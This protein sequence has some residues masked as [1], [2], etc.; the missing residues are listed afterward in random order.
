VK[1]FS[2]VLIVLMVMNL[3]VLTGCKNE[4]ENEESDFGISNEIDRDEIIASIKDAMMKAFEEVPDPYLIGWTFSLKVSGL[5]DDQMAELYLESLFESLVVDKEFEYDVGKPLRSVVTDTGY[6]LVIGETND[7]SN[8]FASQSAVTAE[9]TSYSVSHK[10]PEDVVYSNDQVVVQI[11]SI[12]TSSYDVPFIEFV[13]IEGWETVFGT[14]NFERLGPGSQ[15][16]QKDVNVD[17]EIVDGTVETSIPQGDYRLTFKRDDFVFDIIL[18]DDYVLLTEGNKMIT[19]EGKKIV[20]GKVY[21]GSSSDEDKEPIEDAEVKLVPLMTDAGIED[22]FAG[23]TDSNGEYNIPD[24]PIGAYLAFVNGIEQH[25]ITIDQAGNGEWNVD[26][27]F[28]A[29]DS[30]DITLVIKLPLTTTQVEY[31]DV[32]I[33]DAYIQP[34][35]A[36]SGVYNITKDS[37]VAPSNYISIENITG[38]NPFYRDNFFSILKTDDTASGYLKPNTYYLNYYFEQ[39]WL[40]D[41]GVAVLDE[42]TNQGLV[43]S[44][45]DFYSGEVDTEAFEE[46]LNEGT[47]FVMTHTVSR[48]SETTITIVPH[49]E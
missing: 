46:L 45:D 6:Y 32:Y 21:Q 9:N 1:L 23:T 33:G 31:T 7:I 22:E 26:D 38:R 48:Y 42:V 30:Y 3:M 36:S 29:E 49:E 10:G 44:A 12:I 19:L 18:D 4:G 39:Y 14:L 15:S 37:H 8:P 27:M 25:I 43:V 11:S 40:D 24:V 16:E 35:Q 20:K 17:A 47:P 2:K 34:Y 28:M 13:Q 41:S 5:E